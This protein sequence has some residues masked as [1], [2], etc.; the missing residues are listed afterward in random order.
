MTPTGR[1][2]WQLSL[3]FGSLYLLTLP[4]QPYFGS[5]AIKG[6]SIATLAWVAWCGGS[7]LLASALAASSVG[8]VLLDIGPQDLFVPGLAAF[9]TAHLLYAALFVRRRRRA[10]LGYRLAASIPP[11]LFAAAFALWLAPELGPLQL[12]V[13]LYILVIA[14]MLVSSLFAAAPLTVPA[15]A[16]L[17][18]LS[19]SILAA[20]RF[21]S[22]LPFSAYLIWIT[23][24]AAQFLI[25]RGMIQAI[26]PR[27]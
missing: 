27:E 3:L 19:D 18:L 21:K 14:A 5:A 25:T 11:A 6:L 2:G 13:N 17:F 12:P 20:G 9:L 16:F 4:A 23:Y 1:L 8:D 26:R 7:R 10:D 22:P 24:Y 15:G